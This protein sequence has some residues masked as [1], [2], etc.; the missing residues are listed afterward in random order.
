VALEQERSEHTNTTPAKENTGVRSKFQYLF[1]VDVSAST[2]D[3]NMINAMSHLRE[4]APFVKVL[5]SYGREE[6]SPF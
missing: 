2:T 3:Q 6:E 1:Y 5:G 4:D